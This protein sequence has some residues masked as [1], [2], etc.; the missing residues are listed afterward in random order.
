MKSELTGVDPRGGGDVVA[1]NADT[2]G[3]TEHEHPATEGHGVRT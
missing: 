1:T 2:R 3:A